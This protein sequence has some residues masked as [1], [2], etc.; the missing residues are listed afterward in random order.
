MA[1]Q[2]RPI[3]DTFTYHP[4]PE[5][6]LNKYLLKRKIFSFGR[7]NTETYYKLKNK[8][9][10]TWGLTPHGYTA[11]ESP[12]LAPGVATAWRYQKKPI[13]ILI[14]QT[15]PRKG[16]ITLTL[17]TPEEIYIPVYTN[18]ANG[19]ATLNQRE[20]PSHQG[21]PVQTYAYQKYEEF[22]NILNESHRLICSNPREL[23]LQG[24]TLAKAWW[25]KH[26]PDLIN[27]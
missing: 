15:A 20:T 13:D 21:F 6:L 22:L 10:E 2:F 8:A 7:L 27:Y 25:T 5:Q 4:S 16:R 14:Y 19:K 23:I 18:A 12:D 17:Q 24:N 9:E 1:N 3:P 26:N 11:V